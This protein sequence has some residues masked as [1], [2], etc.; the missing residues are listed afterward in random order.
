M[1][2]TPLGVSSTEGVADV[3]AVADCCPVPCC[4][5]DVPAATGVTL[6]LEEIVSVLSHGNIVAMKDSSNS[7]LSRRSSLQRSSGCRASR[8]WTASSIAR[9]F[10]ARSDTTVSCTAA[11]HLPVAGS[12]P[13]GTRGSRESGGGAGSRPAERAF[14]GRGI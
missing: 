9:R 14:P 10:R 3:K 2:C 6:N 11:A 13:S 4:Y 5:Y 1:L 7:A 12:A 8:Y